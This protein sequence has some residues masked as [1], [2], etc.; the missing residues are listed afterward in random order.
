MRIS[1]TAALWT[2]LGAGSYCLSFPEW[3]IFW[4]TPLAL[5]GYLFALE[6]V[7]TRKQA[8]VLGFVASFVI[9]IGG[10]HW[11]AYVASN[12]G[13]LP[14]PVAVLILLAFCLIAA[15]QVLC[16]FIAG[17]FVQP[18]VREKIPAFVQPFFWATLYVALEFL[19]SRLKVFPE[20]L[21]SPWIHCLPIA[22]SASFGGAPFLSFLPALLGASLYGLIRTKKA[23][24]P[25]FTM[26]I[27]L[28][29]FLFFWGQREIARW[30]AREANAQ[31]QLK[32]AIAQANIGDVEKVAAEV[33]R[34]EAIDFV[35]Q[36]YLHLSKEAAARKVDL[37]VWPETAFPLYFPF[38]PTIP[39]SEL[40]TGYTNQMRSGIRASGVPHLIGTYE[41]DG[42]STYNAGALVSRDGNPL[43]TYRK[44]QLLILGEYMPFAT[45]FPEIKKLNPNLGDFNRG[46]GAY[47]LEFRAWSDRPIVELGV[48]ICYEAIMPEYMRE[49]AMRGSNVF[50]NITN[51]SWFG[52]TFEPWQHLQL[53]Q[54]RT[55]ED[56][57]PMVRATNTGVSA[58][59]STTGKIHSSTPIFQKQLL[60]DNVPVLSTSSF[61]KRHGDL[62]AWFTVVF[63]LVLSLLAFSYPPLRP[64]RR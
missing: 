6:N 28:F 54:L 60:I 56:R 7:A 18:K 16:F 47:P 51:D 34:R 33:G 10:F 45:W 42:A 49:L 31:D 57:I 15:P 61:Y 62:F 25:A 55:I 52:P 1:R 12:F 50:I 44:S 39:R 21:G 58:F 9:G 11:I 35:I 53:A 20:F 23:A 41:N 5:F 29:V 48:S 59:I 37:V 17:Q 26:A 4:L 19:F 3:D 2:L 27:G 46:K 43:L 13:E 8:T 36:R 32:I 38:P 22:Q 14:I 24:V 64:K 40:A 30:E 63:S